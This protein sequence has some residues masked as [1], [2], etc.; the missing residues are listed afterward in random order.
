[1]KVRVLS[2]SGI[3]LS[4][5][6]AAVLLGL[7]LTSLSSYLLFH[8]LV[9]VITAAVGISIFFLA[10]NARQHMDTHYLLFIGIAYLFIA[11]VDLMHALA[12]KGMGVFPADSNLATQLSIPGR[13]LQSLSLLMA[14]LF[15]RR[16]L[17]PAIA[18]LGFSM[19][20]ALL[21]G[22]IFIGAFPDCFIEG[23]GLTPFKKISEYVIALILSVSIL[24]LLRQR[25]RLDTGTT[26]ALVACILLTIGSELAFTTYASVY[27]SSNLLGHLIRL[28][29]YLFLYR[30]IIVSGIRKPFEVLFRD[31]AR[32]REALQKANVT[33]EETVALRTEELRR[34]L[35]ERRRAEEAASQS[36]SRYREVFDNVSDSLFVFDVTGDGRF[37]FSGINAA[38]ARISGVSA[39]DAYG[40]FFEDV[41]RPEQ[42]RQALPRFQRCV[43]SGQPMEYEEDYTRPAAG[44]R[45]LN[46]SLLPLPPRAGCVRRLVVLN[47]DITERVVREHAIT[48]LN[49][50]YRVLSNAN[51]L[52]V[53]EKSRETLLEE[54]CRISVEDG[55]ALMACAGFVDSETGIVKPAA[56][57]G[58]EDG[59][60]SSVT[61]S[62]RNEPLGRGPTGVAIR[63]NRHVFVS[64]IA[65]EASMEPWRDEALKR[66]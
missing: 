3:L 44:T 36:E 8:S 11:G 46:T 39:A 14:P 28:L 33:R 41:V 31:L 20:V 15:I 24:L 26:R 51:K 53:H 55:G 57:F 17:Q 61:I 25:T 45:H 5:S 22:S 43:E 48:Q 6:G 16:K 63:E 18:F 29:A 9:E 10:W 52:I 13:Y 50:V 23:S 56:W 12:Y 19:A 32:S 42:V 49:R 59:Y 2:A 62:S 65:A 4:L 37:V 64:D 35:A 27:G 38:A 30:A 1:M 21:L 54:V 66:G 47:R 34:E 7:F 40:R 60:L 58:K